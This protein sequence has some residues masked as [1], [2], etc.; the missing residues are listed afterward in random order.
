MLKHATV[1]SGL[2]SFA[3]ESSES[4]V[5]RSSPENTIGVELEL[6]IIDPQTGDLAAGAVRILKLCHEEGLSDVTAELMQ[7]MIELKTGVCHNA[8]EAKQQLVP[9]LRRVRNI[10]TSLGYQLAWGGT[11]PF[12]RGMVG[13]VSP[14]ER[15]ERIQ[16]R[17]A[18]IT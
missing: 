12:S 5:F 4:L 1:D 6:Q 10:A 7:S 11:H 16:D 14:G 17:L 8:T 3:P 2:A 13:A 18:W 9:L 15:Y